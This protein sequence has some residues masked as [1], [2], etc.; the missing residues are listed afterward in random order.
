MMIEKFNS[1]ISKTSILKGIQCPKA[2]YLSRNPPDFEIQPDPDTESKLQM[3][4]EVG[5]LA[6]QL[7]PGGVEI[8]FA[9][10]SIEEQAAR[11][12]EHIEAGDN[13]R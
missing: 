8:P 5:V 1:C 3:G 7:F 11:T 2:L 6:R 13:V 4:R 9:D 12:R 10:L